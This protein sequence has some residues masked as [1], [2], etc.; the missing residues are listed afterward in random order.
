MNTGFR[1]EIEQKLGADRVLEPP[2]ALPQTAGRLDPSGPVRPYEFEVSVE[3]LM[4]VSQHRGA[5][6]L[7]P[8]ADRRPDRPDRRLE[9]KAP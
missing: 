3:R 7:R 4:V 2:G 1:G 5:L 9:G 6:R 8:G